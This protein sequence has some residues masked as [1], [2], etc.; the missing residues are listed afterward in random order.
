MASNQ[1]AAPLPFDVLVDEVERR[2]AFVRFVR[3]DDWPPKAVVDGWCGELRCLFQEAYTAGMCE[4]VWD[5]VNA[6]RTRA[7]LEREPKAT[8]TGQSNRIFS[9]LQ[10]GHITEIL[11]DSFNEEELRLFYRIKLNINDGEFVQSS[12]ST[13]VIAFNLVDYCNRHGRIRELMD[14]IGKE[15]KHMAARLD[16]VFAMKA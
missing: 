9:G 8:P 4:V 11:V 6:F 14:A 15:R 16:Q 5:I 12:V 1:L 3:N 7:N 10:L 2:L 13:K